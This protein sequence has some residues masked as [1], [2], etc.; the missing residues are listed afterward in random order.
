MRTL[1][2]TGWALVAFGVLLFLVA[3]THES[4]PMKAA[5]TNGEPLC[6]MDIDLTEPLA[7]IGGALSGVAGILSLLWDARRRSSGFD[8]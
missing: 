5:C 3:G 1:Q 8:A 2:L 4:Q 6:G 7:A